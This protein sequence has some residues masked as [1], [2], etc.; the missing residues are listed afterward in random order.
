MI[1]ATASFGVAAFS[2]GQGGESLVASADKALYQA[3]RAGRNRA[4]CAA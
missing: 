1:R 3:K 2:V 4:T